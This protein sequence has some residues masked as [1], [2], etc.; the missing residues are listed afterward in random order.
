MMSLH[1]SKPVSIQDRTLEF[2]QCVS[3]FNKQQNKHSKIGNGG[4]NSP[5]IPQTSKSQFSQKASAIAKDIARVTNSLSKLAVL[6]M[7]K[8]IF[9]DRPTDMVELTYVIKQDIFKIE[10]Q[11]KDLQHS[12]AGGGSILSSSDPQVNGFSKNVIQL[13]NT[14]IKNV[15]EEFK[16]V[17]EARQRNELAYRS[18]QEQLLAIS[19]NGMGSNDNSG[20]AT[21]VGMSAASPP[22]KGFMSPASATV[23][24]GLRNKQVASD[25]PFLTSLNNS[26]DDPETSVPMITSSNVHNQLAPQEQDFLSIPDQTNQLLLLEEQNNVYLQDRNRAVEAI[27]KTIN[28]VG[29]LFQQLATMVNEQ[30]EV[31]QRIDNNVEDIS[32]NI[33]G[34]QRELL[35]YYH[36]V[37]NNRWLIAKMFGVL[38][39]FFLLWVLVS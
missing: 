12:I 5:T 30:G 28:E 8:Q 33:T 18:R 1:A 7:Q 35:K 24:Y 20:A 16:T 31:I 25:N 21:P 23:P 10:R 37:S 3:T 22:R 6:A 9:S 17:L 36:N 39:L 15:S 27:E 32:V 34:A 13:L 14:K 26:A 29:S 2:Q 38:I 19:S 4:A 11:L